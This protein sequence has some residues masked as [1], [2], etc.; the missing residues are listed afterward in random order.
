MHLL[1]YYFIRLASSLFDD[2]FD[3]SLL[4][5]FYRNGVP[6]RRESEWR[7]TS[8]VYICRDHFFVLSYF[9]VE[10][11]KSIVSTDWISYK[12]RR[13]T[14]QP[15]TNQVC[16]VNCKFCIML[17]ANVHC[18]G[19]FSSRTMCKFLEKWHLF[20]SILRHKEWSGISWY[21]V[22]LMTS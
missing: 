21:L 17:E 3:L 4:F 15:K 12:I 19:H 2:F 1:L 10:Y 6:W 16:A 20:F 11:W 14:D 18:R 9:Y 8:R 13:I 22:Y 5:C 7:P